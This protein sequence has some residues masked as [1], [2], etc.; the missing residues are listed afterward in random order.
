M[1]SEESR[2][3]VIA[4]LENNPQVES[5]RVADQAHMAYSLIG[6][7][8]WGEDIEGNPLD[9][10]HRR[11]RCCV[12]LDRRADRS[13]GLDTAADGPHPSPARL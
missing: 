11:F 9:I 4:W 1:Q 8:I 12:P 5:V 3:A 6:M 2:N 10:Q 7:N 13:P